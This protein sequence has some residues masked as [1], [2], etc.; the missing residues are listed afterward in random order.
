MKKK[1]FWIGLLAAWFLFG[2]PLT[3][4]GD[5]I[6]RDS[7]R[8]KPLY[9]NV[10][11]R[12]TV[13]EWRVPF[14]TGDRKNIKTISVVSVFGAKR[15]SYVK[16]HFHTGLDMIPKKRQGTDTYTYVYAMAPG[17]VCSIHLGHPHKTVVVKHKLANGETVFTSYKHMQEIYLETGQHVTAETKVGRLYTRAE[18]RRLGGNYHHLHLEIRKKFDDYGV[19]SWATIK[20]NDLEARFHDPYLFMKQ[21]IK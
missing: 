19:A 21:N 17:T 7:G 13:K 18:A 1:V 10:I 20:K 16:G 12:Q 14:N 5:H 6:E 11:P 3:G 9:K 2:L 15:L 4:S 8:W